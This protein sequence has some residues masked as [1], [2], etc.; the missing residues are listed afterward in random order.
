MTIPESRGDRE[1]QKFVQT[2]AGDTSART[3]IY[4]ITS[5]GAILPV[6]VDTDGKLVVTV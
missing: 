1:N 4:G 6:L 5:G 2:N 3:H